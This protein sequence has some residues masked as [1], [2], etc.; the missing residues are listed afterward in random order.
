MRENKLAVQIIDSSFSGQLLC[1]L[2]GFFAGFVDSIAGGGGLITL[3]LLALQF[4]I[5]PD[6]I[7]TN[8]IIGVSAAL[9]ALL[10]YARKGHLQWRAGAWFVASVGVGSLGGS[11]LLPHLRQ[12]WIRWL[13]IGLLPFLLY[14]IWRKDRWAKISH[15]TVHQTKP[16]ALI[17]SGLIC[18]LY[19]GAIGPAGGTFMFLSLAFWANVPLLSA[20]AIGKLANTVSAGTSLVS[21]SLQGFVHWQVG[22]LVASGVIVG[23]FFGARL[24]TKGAEKVVRPALAVVTVLLF[25]RLMSS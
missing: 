4:G 8:K 21:Y 5:G 13:L 9:V 12:E 14:V 25:L 11:L 3:P 24:A 2:G 15:K 16:A 7:G 19:D 18:G 22:A 6:A 20:L 10:V 1:V 17:F 23:A